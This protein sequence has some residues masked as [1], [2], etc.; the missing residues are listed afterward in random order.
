MALFSPYLLG[1]TISLYVGFKTYK[2]YYSNDF[3]Y[4]IDDDEENISHK[5]LNS[6]IQEHQGKNEDNKDINDS[7]DD[8]K[9]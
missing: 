4:L 1:G 5:Y 9:E 7:N 3:E 2:S 6:D 8:I